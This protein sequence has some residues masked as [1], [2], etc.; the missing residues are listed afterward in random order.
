MSNQHKLVGMFWCFSCMCW[1]P[2]ML[3]DQKKSHP[4]RKKCLPCS[5]KGEE[6]H[7]QEAKKPA[8]GALTKRAWSPVRK[9]RTLA[10]LMRW[11]E[12]VE[13]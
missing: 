2:E 1:Q 6:R 9:A 12:K 4:G 3:L 11:I 5:A 7:R 10:N 8:T 13:R